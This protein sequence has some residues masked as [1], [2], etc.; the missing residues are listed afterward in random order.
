MVSANTW[1]T[2]VKYKKATENLTHY[3]DNVKLV[4]FDIIY[5]VFAKEN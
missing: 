4:N 1:F 5:N 2:E 3:F